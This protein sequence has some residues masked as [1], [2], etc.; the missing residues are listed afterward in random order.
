MINES[1]LEQPFLKQ[2]YPLAN[3]PKRVIIFSVLILIAWQIPFVYGIALFG[4]VSFSDVMRI[5]HSVF[6]IAL[7]FV[8]MASAYG[9]N[10]YFTKILQAYHT[11]EDAY[12]RA[13]KA[14][15]QYESL[16]IGIPVLLSIIM[17]VALVHLQ[18]PEYAGTH[19]LHAI[20]MFSVGHCFLY[21][22][23]CYI[24]FIQPFEEWLCVIPLH[25]DFRGMPLKIRSVLTSFFSLTG[26]LLVSLAPI[27]VL[28]PEDSVH[29][30]LFTKTLPFAAVGLIIALADSYLQT[31][32]AAFRLQKIVD[33]TAYMAKGD[34]TQ[35]KMT[36]LSRDE[37][38]FLMQEVN[39][40]QNITANLLMQISQELQQLRAV[41]SSLVTNMTVTAGSAAHINANIDGVKR[42]TVT[43]ADSVTQTGKTVEKISRTIVQLNK[44]IEVQRE[45]ILQSSNSIELLVSNITSITKTLTAADEAIKKLAAATA[46]G[47]DTLVNSSSVTQKIAEESG[48]LL[49]ASSVIQHIASQTNLLAMNAAIEAAHA[50]EAG[51]GFAV[52]ADE[53]R[54]LAEESSMQ[55]KTI[56]AT[57]KDLSMEIEGLSVSSKT[58]QDKFNV[59][60]ALSEKVKDM[61][62]SIMQSMRQQEQ[63]SNEIVRVLKNINEVTQE[64]HRGSGE[65]L[66]GSN[67]VAQ[68]MSKL[69][70]LTDAITDSMN[71]MMSGA[72]QINDAVKAV[73]EITQ[74]NKQSIDILTDEVNRFT[75]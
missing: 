10:R 30:V 60:F 65:M 50:G 55:G 32:G 9:L 73:D 3:P 23:L 42:Q 48:S 28:A 62:T 59:I 7:F 27:V 37:F 70:S 11:G 24:L 53:I 26:T 75:V 22:L 21:A 56:T 8:T 33:F 49:E 63:G 13:L 31:G 5:F 52:V 51:K 72:V 25:Q 44:G 58:A 71:E 74:K 19:V 20:V 45:S 6:G 68:E 38:G 14:I 36:I 34:Y 43:Q 41:S 29:T 16:L 1:E 18:A 46:D 57:L 66:E 64:V 39:E 35:E 15:K 67:E 61:S 40:F 2:A 69:A 17:P 12:K 54:K 4:I 47:R